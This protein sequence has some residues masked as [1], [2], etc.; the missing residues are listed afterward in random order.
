[1]PGVRQTNTGVVTTA[2]GVAETAAATIIDSFEDQDFSEYSSSNW[3][4]GTTFVTDGSYGAEHS[5][6]S[7]SLADSES[8]L[9][10]YPS[11]GDKF[12]FDFETT[13]STS[14]TSDSWELRIG[15]AWDSA[16]N[17]WY[18]VHLDVVNGDFEVWARDVNDRFINESYSYSADTHYSVTV[19]WD[20]GSTFGGSAGDMTVTLRDEDAGTQ[21]VQA[22]DNDTS[23]T[24]GGVRMQVISNLSQTFYFDY[25]RIV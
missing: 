9:N 12:K 11:Q 5:G 7:G 25:W 17:N 8:G 18:E 22:S 1:M 20:D 15:W 10:A 2:S 21:E 3:T 19:E 16:N 23:W 4:T 14:N 13:V 24:S 6:T